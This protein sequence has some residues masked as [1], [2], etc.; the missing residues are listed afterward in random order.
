MS[1]PQLLRD[2]SLERRQWR[3]SWS[4][5]QAL[6]WVESELATMESDERSRYE[7]VYDA[8]HTAATTDSSNALDGSAR[9]ASWRSADTRPSGWST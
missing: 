1:D 6:Q 7:Q 3:R 8:T 2:V 9:A 4:R 5:P